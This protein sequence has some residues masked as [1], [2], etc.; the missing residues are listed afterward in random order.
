MA[1]KTGLVVGV[2]EQL[3]YE[4]RVFWVFTL[5]EAVIVVLFLGPA[6]WLFLNLNLAFFH[7]V[8]ISGFVVFVGFVLAKFKPIREYV[9]NWLNYL[10]GF[11][12]GTWT[13]SE[14]LRR[15]VS[16][17][18]V[19]GEFVFLQDGRM[20]SILSV[21]P[22]DFSVLSEQEKQMLV[23]GFMEFLNSLSFPVQIVM[24]TTKVNLTDYFSKSKLEMLK[25]GDKEAFGY[26]EKFE[27]FV[28]GYVARHS[29]HDR[30]FYLVIPIEARKTENE[31]KRELANRTDILHNKLNSLNLTSTLLKDS[32]LVNLYASFFEGFIESDADYLFPIT[33]LDYHDKFYEGIAKAKK[34]LE[35][36]RARE[37]QLFE[38]NAKTEVKAPVAIKK[39]GAKK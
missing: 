22:L 28:N 15:F 1:E 20:V 5:Q 4:E 29:V 18:D 19:K 16:V 35:E 23:Y 9:W 3:S 32:K 14:V 36:N 30:L 33:M 10:V 37:K 13:D 7:R 12:K 27:V 8:L 39:R 2:P 34:E 25:K 11:K 31:A 6:A 17:K 24:R 21:R 26:M 38:S